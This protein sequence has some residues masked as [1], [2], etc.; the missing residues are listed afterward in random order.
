MGGILTLPIQREPGSSSAHWEIMEL[1]KACGPGMV[2][3]TPA[4]SLP[5]ENTTVI[6]WSDRLMYIK[7]GQQVDDHRPVDPRAR[8][9]IAMQNAHNR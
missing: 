6:V 5:A 8:S 7:A 1:A 2:N 4:G 9:I 3:I